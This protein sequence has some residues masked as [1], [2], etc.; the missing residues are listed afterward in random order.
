M[1]P[2]D[3]TTQQAKGSEMTE[4]GG[5]RFEPALQLWPDELPDRL[6][7]VD[8]VP[9]LRPVL[10]AAKG[11]SGRPLASVIVCP[12]GGYNHLADHEA[13]PVA[14]RLAQMGLAA[15]VL[16]YRIKPYFLASS[17]DDGRRA[18][19]LVRRMASVWDLDARKVAVLGFSAGGHLAASISTI[20][21]AGPVGDAVDDQPA[22]PDALIACYAPVSLPAMGRGD[23]Y[24]WL[25]GPDPSDE[26]LR[27]IALD[28]HVTAENPP[29]FLWH[30]SADTVVPARQSIL[31]ARA[32]QS[33]GV[34][35]QLHLFQDGRHGLGLA[36]EVSEAAA[37]PDLL[38][39]W[40]AGLGWLGDAGEPGSD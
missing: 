12:G 36:E 40:L 33:A 26:L 29:T 32:L 13:E 16:R 31:M 8:Q 14:R 25:T 17:L 7:Q 20:D 38:A 6:D 27:C 39:D 18:V 4:D 23:R 28:R 3:E 37:W 22:R 19:R 2:F 11:R 5:V 10:P 1:S 34:D 15:F 9:T 35:V 24:E 21:A 30:T